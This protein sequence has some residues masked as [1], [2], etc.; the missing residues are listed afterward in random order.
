MRRTMRIEC[1]IDEQQG[2]QDDGWWL[3]GCGWLYHNIHV[4]AELNCG[5]LSYQLSQTVIAKSP[6]IFERFR[7]T[8]LRAV[9]IL[10]SVVSSNLG[11]VSPPKIY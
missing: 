2:T 9:E 5:P 8:V 11:F 6:H 10:H 3:T 1:K 4:A 7:T